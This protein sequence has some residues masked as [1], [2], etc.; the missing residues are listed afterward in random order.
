MCP[1]SRKR[2]QPSLATNV[3]PSMVQTPAE[4]DLVGPMRPGTGT[5]LLQLPPLGK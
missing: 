1:R 4:I 5:I 3:S 2:D